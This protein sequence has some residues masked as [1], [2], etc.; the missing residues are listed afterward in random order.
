MARYLCDIALDIQRDW[1]RP[2]FGAVPYIEALGVLTGIHDYY[3]ADR[4]EDLVRYFL[5][6]AT[7]WRGPKA[8]EIKAELREML[9][10]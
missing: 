1:K 8:R 10:A 5:A 9:K 6:N 2:Y 7:T 3:G 4:A